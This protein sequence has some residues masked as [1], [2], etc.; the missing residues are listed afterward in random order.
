MIEVDDGMDRAGVD[1]QE[2]AVALAKEIMGFEHLRLEGIT[3]Y[4]GHC[5]V[6]FDPQLLIDKQRAAMDMFLQVADRLESVGIP[7]PIRSAGG[8]VSWNLTAGCRGVTEIQAGSYVLMDNFHGQRTP[9]GFEHALTVATTVISRAPNRLIVD[10]GNKSIGVGGGPTIVGGGP[11]IVGVD[12][13]AL[14]FDEENGI[15]IAGSEVDL[16][17]GS[18]LQLVPGCAPATVNMYDNYYVVVDDRV[19]DVWPVFPRGPEHNGLVE[20]P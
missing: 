1:T 16:P 4:E 19:V 3:G 11:T 13:E 14:R 20:V 8:T 15:F 5:S 12:L 2:D 9:G 6:E 7:C 10:A 18:W 17:V